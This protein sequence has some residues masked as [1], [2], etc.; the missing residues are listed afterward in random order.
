MIFMGY[1]GKSGAHPFET[2]IW[3]YLYEQPIYLDTLESPMNR[4]ML[5]IG[6]AL[7]VVSLSLPL[8]FYLFSL[9]P[10][11]FVKGLIIGIDWFCCLGISV[12]ILISGLS[13]IILAARTG[14]D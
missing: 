10:L 13:L 8:L 12:L 7:S 2:V 11:E 14:N 4:K 3:E 5:N 9:V 1:N 6:L